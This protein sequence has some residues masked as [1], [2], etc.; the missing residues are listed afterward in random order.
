ML[1]LLAIVRL[2]GLFSRAIW[3]DEAITLL[4]M[5]GHASPS[6]PADEPKPA[7][8][9]KKQFEGLPTLSKIT[10]QLI[11]TDI[12]PPVYYWC[13][14]MWRQC[15]GSSLE[16]ARSFSL[17]CSLG[18]ILIFYLLL[19]EG[20]IRYPLIPAFIFGLSTSSVHYAHEARSYSLALFF[21]TS[22]AFFAF[23]ADRIS[24]R[25]KNC[26][27]LYSLFMAI[28]CGL[29]FGTHYLALFPVAGILL[30][31]LFNQWSKS[32]FL[33]IVPIILAGVI[34]LIAIFPL[35][36]QI[37]QR[38]HQFTSFPGF[39][40]TA[41]MLIL[42]NMHVF[43]SSMVG[44]SAFSWFWVCLVPILIGVS[45]AQL[46]KSWSTCNRK[47]I[48][49]ILLLAITPTFGLLLLDISFN[50]N[51]ALCRYLVF[52]AP[53][54]SVVLS[55]GIINLISSK[56]RIGVLLLGTLLVFQLTGINWGKE[57]VPIYE[58]SNM[59]SIAK[60]IKK[61]SSSSH[62]VVIGA[63]YG[64]GHP[65]T[66]IY[67]LDP[68]TKILLLNKNTHMKDLIDQVVNYEDVWLIRDHYANRIA[69]DIDKKFLN[70]LKKRSVYK[71]ILSKTYVTFMSKTKKE[72]KVEIK[73]F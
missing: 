67:E 47:F 27:G 7:Y 41:S 42:M 49:L 70:S 20:Q 1:A 32:T 65:G 22:G 10:D 43:Y 73:D 71:S 53:A 26:A 31:H 57:S 11:K 6:W 33:A 54:I 24:D 44:L 25:D 37:G 18:T 52:S 23:L 13:L 64:R 28:F 61:F 48:W 34:A 19:R 8:V 68:E 38:P 12:H 39:Y 3:Y 66:V 40:H 29:A 46:L 62:L 4:E 21:I 14:S 45:T 60:A 72:I 50:K 16:A 63:G 9:A 35:L 5:A 15:F 2:P 17:I 55:Y 59:R 36:S 51:L 30:W 58:G 69:V 56:K